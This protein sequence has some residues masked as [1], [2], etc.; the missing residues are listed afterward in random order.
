MTRGIIG[1]A[2]LFTTLAIAAAGL[3]VGASLPA[4]AQL[5]IHWGLDGRPDRLADKWTAL[6]LPAVM[7]GGV[8]LLFWFLPSLEPRKQGLERRQGLYFAGWIGILLVCG[9]VQLSV[10]SVALG[11]DVP[12]NRLICIALGAM[13]VLIGNQLGKSRSMHM[14]GVRTPW[15]LASE[16]IWIR[17]H[18]LAGKL[19]VSA[20]LVA[21]L[22][23]VLPLP[24][25]LMMQ[26]MLAVI[27]VAAV[28]PIVYSWLLW[29][30]ER[31]ASE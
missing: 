26:G 17:T 8:S 2:A 20:G 12:A 30:R 10:V 24:P 13:L 23:A 14:I 31:Q 5:P 1:L 3:A 9:A 7:T 27:L 16:E 6:L 28:I 18:R 15:T 21:M 4:D 11:W 25:A 19:M 22:A 29:R